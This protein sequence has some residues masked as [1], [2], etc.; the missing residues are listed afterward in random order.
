MEEETGRASEHNLSTISELVKKRQQA[1]QVCDEIGAAI[2]KGTLGRI[3]AEH[4]KLIQRYY[5]DV[6]DQANNSFETAK[7]IA[8]TGFAVL[9]CTLLYV[10]VSNTLDAPTADSGVINPLRYVG[11]V[12]IVS[13]ILIEFV[14]GVAFWL[15][16]R[17]A[18]QFIAFHI[19]LERTHR[20]LTAYTMV[21]RLGTN[22]DE[23]LRDLVCIMANARMITLADIDQYQANPRTTRPVAPG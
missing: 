3:V 15:Y 17:C 19:C 11:G 23:T 21:E 12:G 22:K 8:V 16:T 7:W 18:R 13:G 6:Q 14:A 5:Y 4:Q 2:D 10:L 20:Y 1:E 9:I